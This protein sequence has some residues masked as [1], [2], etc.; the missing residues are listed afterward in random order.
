MPTYQYRCN[1]CGYEFEEFQGISDRPIESCPKCRN[2]LVR[3][4]TG[5]AGFLLKGSGFYA[6][7][8]RPASYKE[9]E[10]REKDVISPPGKTEDK[11][12]PALST[13]KNGQKSAK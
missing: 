11:K 12:E 8:Y 2:N 1:S 5:G 7:D 6:T 13:G 10:K 9:A 4:I 3:V